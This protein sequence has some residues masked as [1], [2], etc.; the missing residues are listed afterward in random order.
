MLSSLLNK[1]LHAIANVDS[2]IS[3]LGHKSKLC[4]K[5][6][7]K[8][9]NNY[10]AESGIQHITRQESQLHEFLTRLESNFSSS[11]S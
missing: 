1:E 7:R 10:S 4:A 6:K 3:V 9:A 2:V 8:K 11:P 5:I